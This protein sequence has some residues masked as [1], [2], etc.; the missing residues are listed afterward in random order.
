VANLNAPATRAAR[1]AHD[2]VEI[3]GGLRE[4]VREALSKKGYAIMG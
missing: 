2:A 1:F 4:R 3:Q